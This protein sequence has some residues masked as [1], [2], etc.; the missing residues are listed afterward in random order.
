MAS[1]MSIQDG[2]FLGDARHKDGS[3]MAVVFQ[4]CVMHCVR[5]YAWM[6]VHVHGCA[7]MHACMVVTREAIFFFCAH[8]VK[9]GS[10]E[11]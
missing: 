5:A 11:R 6:C 9:F 2:T 10:Y 3:L 4:V 1:Q 7:C 8:I